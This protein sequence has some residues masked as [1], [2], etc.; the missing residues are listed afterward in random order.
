[1]TGQAGGS[2]SL[3]TCGVALLAAMAERI[4]RMLQGKAKPEDLR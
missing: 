3:K 2:F 4:D 1:M